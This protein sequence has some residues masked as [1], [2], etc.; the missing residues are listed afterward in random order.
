M[1]LK[2]V[3]IVGFKSFADKTK[4]DFKPGMSAII[5]P[6]GSGKSNVNEAIRWCIGEMS[7]KSLRST[8]MVDVIFAGTARRQ[9]L[10]MA[11]VTLTFDNSKGMLPMPYSEITVSRKLFRTGESEYY[12]NK[13]Q[14]RLRDIRELF[15][16]TGLGNDGYAIIDQGG[17]DA[18]IRSKPEER[19]AFFEEAAGVAKYNA[20]REEALRKL[21]RV[22]MDLGRLQDCVVLIE[23]QVK[24]LDSDARRAKLYAKYK[25]ELAALEA[26]HILEQASAAE[27]E[28]ASMQERIGPVEQLLGERR[29]QIGAEGANLAALNLEKTGEQNR[30]I[31]A[32]QKVAET[33]TAIGRLE[34][35][36]R[37]S[38][39]SIDAMDVR[40]AA[41]AAEA[42][43]DGVRAAAV[44]PEIAVVAESV[45]QAEAALAEARARAQAAEA[46]FSAIE[47]RAREAQAL[48]DSLAKEAVAKVQQAYDLGRRLAGAESELT[49]AVAQARASL[50]NLERD[51]VA[52]AET[53]GRCVEVRAE[54]SACSASLASAKAAAE[55]AES[56][57]EALCRRQSELGEEALRLHSDLAHAQARRESLESRGGQNPYWVGAQAVLNARIPGTIGTVRGLFRVEDSLKPAL[58]DLLGEKLFAVVVEDSS[59]A[60]AG[61]EF[62]EAAGSGRARFLVV[63]A[64][65]DA[66]EP[67][68]PQEAR[69][70]ISRLQ[71]EPRHERVVRHLFAEAYELGG[72]LFGAHW[73]YGGCAPQDGPQPTLADLGEWQEKVV[74]LESRGAE[75]SDERAR[76]ETA[77]GEARAAA[78]AA[79]AALSMESNRAHGLEAR[80]SQLEQSLENHARNVELSTEESARALAQIA[81]A[82][83]ALCEAQIVRA[84]AEARVEAARAEELKAAEALAAAREELAGKRA[85]FSAQEGRMRGVQD[86]LAAYESSRKRLDD[87]KAELEASIRRLSAEREDISRRKDETLEA[88]RRMRV[89]IL[90]FSTTLA[91]QENESKSVFDRMQDLQLKIDARGAF[92]KTLQAEHDQAQAD[93]NQHQVHAAA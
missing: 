46:E 59:A 89:E 60:R 92:L 61:I 38:S 56:A 53:R 6:N 36:L 9:P 37:S 26:A 31:E 22:D 14:C 19:R 50:R 57:A 62:L 16:D 12:L 91:V 33:K 78:R 18:M 27:I 20:K 24:K 45:A 81:A 29:S 3:E 79:A 25:E 43:T 30:L 71:Y 83:E 11:E 49:R 4:L 7:W 66:P 44:A 51:A 28:L 39:S 87:E 82:K 64:L 42:E 54:I 76:V 40:A 35:R 80:V 23:E 88:Q 90:E 70:L 74:S 65:N 21:D 68:Y 69:P 10:N 58:E 52:A 8:A 55:S 17:V 84:G 34:E 13:T 47:A 85:E 15:L 5:G 2:S 41:C 77:L 48:K 75:L 72:K 32:N 67:L 93:L 73:V 1:H 86:Q 63:S